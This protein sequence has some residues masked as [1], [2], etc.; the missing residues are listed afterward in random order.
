MNPTEFDQLVNECLNDLARA[1]VDGDLSI[2]TLDQL[3]SMNPHVDWPHG[4]F[5]TA[6]DHADGYTY[7]EYELCLINGTQEGQTPERVYEAL[8]PSE[9]WLCEATGKHDWVNESTFGPDTG[10]ECGYC[11]RCAFHIDVVWY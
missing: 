9:A 1:D 8:Y 11:R 2:T 5:D 3:E 7:E 6:H 10:H 4:F